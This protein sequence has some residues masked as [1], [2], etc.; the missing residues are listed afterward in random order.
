MF[1][2]VIHRAEALP[3]PGAARVQALA[4]L[5]A[6]IVHDVTDSLAD[7]LG[8][9]LGLDG[10]TV[11]LRSTVLQLEIHRWRSE[12]ERAREQAEQ[13]RRRQEQ[14]LESLTLL[15]SEHEKVSA[16]A[17]QLEIHGYSDALTDLA[18]RRYFDERL[19]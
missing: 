12:L 6:A 19:A 4:H 17:R 8:H 3:A 18:N 7:G 9:L 16:R 13:E 11:R 14:L 1:G 15:R 5:N 10:E 2:T